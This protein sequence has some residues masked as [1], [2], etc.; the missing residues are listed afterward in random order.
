MPDRSQSTS[1]TAQPIARR[2]TFT[3]TAELPPIDGLVGQERAFEA[4]QFG[5]RIDKGGFNLFVIG[6]DGARM[7]DAVKSLLAEEAGKGA[8]PFR[9]GLCQ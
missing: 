7:Q 3:S 6:P 5:M 4:I 1:S 2:L 9:L 8:E